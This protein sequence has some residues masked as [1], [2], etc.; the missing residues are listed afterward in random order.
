MK[1]SAEIFETIV[2]KRKSYRV[3]DTK[4]KIDDDVIERSLKRAILSPNSSNMQ[5]WEF[6]IVK[7]SQDIE[8]MTKICLNQNGARTASHLIVFVARPD[9]WKERQ[10]ALINHL[11]NTIEDKTSKKAK[12]AYSYYKKVMPLFYET[13]FA[14]IRDKIKGIIMWYKARKKPFYRDA[15]SKDVEVVVQKSTAL[16]A[17]TFMLSIVAEGFDSLAMEGFDSVRL[18]KF[19]KLPKQAKINMVVAVGKGKSEGLYGSRFRIPYENV[20]FEV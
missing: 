6:Y 14:F 15:F 2:Q 9:K 8:Q 13:S 3:F 10:K 1:N 5:L 18:K 12:M 20:V 7:K 11:D 19:L 4:Q 17:Q 16:A